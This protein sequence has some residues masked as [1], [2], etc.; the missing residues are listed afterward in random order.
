MIVVCD[1]SPII[2][3]AAIEQIDLLKALF[4]MITV[5]EAVWAELCD[6]D[7]P[8][9]GQRDV[10]AASW[11][12]RAAGGDQALMR[13]LERDLHSGEA[14]AIALAIELDAD[15]IVLD[16]REGR[17]AAT[18]LGLRVVGVVGLVLEAK[19]RGLVAAARP[20]LDDLRNRAGFYL[21]EDVYRHALDLAGELS[22]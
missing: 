6:E 2:N 11:I 15:L 8:W 19:T 7:R 22:D 5:P 14:Q 4:G 17:R 9:P 16:E 12:S 13:S 1:T 10:L 3:L 20:L 18:H 21:S